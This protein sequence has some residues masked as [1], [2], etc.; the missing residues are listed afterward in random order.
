MPIKYTKE[1]I[2]DQ[3][4]AIFKSGDLN[5]LYQEKF[6]NRS[7]NTIDGSEYQE[8]YAQYISERLID[9]RLPM[10][11]LCNVKE[12]CKHERKEKQSPN[13]N[14]E[15]VQRE[16][17]KRERVLDEKYGIPIWYELPTIA[18]GIGKGIDL[19]YYNK[20]TFELNIFELKYN[21]DESLLRAVLEIQTYYQRVNWYKAVKDLKAKERIDTNYISKINK[22][23]LFDCT[24]ENIYKKYSNL[25]EKSYV[26][27]LIDEFNIGIVIY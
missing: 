5:R 17:Y 13:K 25:T 1:T 8:T 9:G 3:I 22:Y 4:A 7:G 24:C 11:S 27:K 21:S 23:V 12:Y 6:L 15:D 18:H 10:I 26:K 19:V 14:E 16:F 20:E 2:L